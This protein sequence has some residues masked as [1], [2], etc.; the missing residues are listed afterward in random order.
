MRIGALDHPRARSRSR[1]DR[2]STCRCSRR[3]CRTSRTPRSATAARI[4]GS[5]ALADPAAEYPA[6]AVALDATL[7]I[8]GTD[9][10][11]QGQG[12][13]LLQGAVRDRP[14]AGR[15]AHRGRIPGRRRRTSARRSSSSRGATATTPSSASPPS[16][17]A[18]R[19][20]SPS[21]APA[22]RRCSR[23][24]PRSAKDA[25][26]GEGR[27]RRRTSQPP[28]DLYHSAATK[29]HL[30]RVLLERAWTTLSTSR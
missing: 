30:A 26:I 3:P 23:R 21:S 22:T 13:R 2:A 1:R 6:C 10:R 8:A 18:A 27:A 14:E 15:A 28:A 4:G 25:R 29:L 20:A 17:A 5:L 19:S 24:T 16:P 12:A 9:G 7:V 11:A